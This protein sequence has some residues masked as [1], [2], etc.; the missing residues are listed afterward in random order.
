MKNMIAMNINTALTTFV[1]QNNTVAQRH[2]ELRHIEGG[3]Q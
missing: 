3:A 2:E 1:F